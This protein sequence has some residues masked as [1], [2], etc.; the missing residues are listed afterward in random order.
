MDSFC[1]NTREA[2]YVRLRGVCFTVV[3]MGKRYVLYIFSVCMFVAVF[4]QY[5][6]RMRRIKMLCDLSGSPHFST[7]SHKRHGFRKRVTEH[8]MCILIFSTTFIWNISH[9]EKN[10][11]RYDHKYTYLYFQSTRYTCQMLIRFLFSRQIF[12]EYSNIKFSEN[13][14]G[15]SRVVACVQTDGQ[16]W[17]NW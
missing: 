2:M 5:E 13:R 14:S 17:W 15:G 3:A 16:T 12:E 6:V 9:S 11:A 1:D 4:I 8:K 10:W 7:L